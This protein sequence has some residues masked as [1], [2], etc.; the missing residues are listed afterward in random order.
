VFGGGDGDV[1][2][3][4]VVNHPAVVG[5]RLR[6]AD[7]CGSR[8]GTRLPAV[9]HANRLQVVFGDE[10]LDRVQVGRPHAPGADEADANPVVGTDNLSIRFRGHSGGGRPRRQS[11]KRN[12]G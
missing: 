6:R 10:R 7:E 4:L 3:V 9:G 2:D 12:G 11:A 1:V 8:F 5:E